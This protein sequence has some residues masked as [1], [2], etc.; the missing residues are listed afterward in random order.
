[1]ATGSWPS[2]L[3]VST[4]L[5]PKG[6]IAPIAELLSQCNDF[7]DDIPFQEANERTAHVFSYRTSIPAGSWFGYYQGVP[8]SKS[9]AAQSRVGLGMLRDYS[10]VDALLAEHSGNIA[11]FRESEDVAFLE[12][13]GQTIV[14]TFFYGNAVTNPN[15]FM[16]FSTFY[17]TLNTSTAANATNVL[18]GGGSG[19]ANASLWLMAWSPTKVY[20]VYPRDSK[21]GLAMEDKGNVTPGFDFLGNR[22]EAYTT[23]FQWQGG[24]CPQDWRNVVRLANLDTTNAGLAGPNAYDIFAGMDQMLLNLPVSSLKTSGITKSD[25]PDEVTT[26]VKP[27]FY[28]NRTVKHWMHIQSIRNRNVL[29]TPTQYDGVVVENYRGI[30]VHVVDQ[31]LNTEA[32]V[33]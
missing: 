24:L 11:R 23:L 21:A 13:M 33:S 2:L 3:D 7:L 26:A 9:T 10:Q 27:V 15:Q 6:N 17:N 16:G 31:L 19:S 22:F 29:L 12:G 5:D 1:M 30:P 4:R 28:C 8:Y 18:S 20:G 14:Q 25:A 32:T